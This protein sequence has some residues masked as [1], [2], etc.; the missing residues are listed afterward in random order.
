MH[1]NIQSVPLVLAMGLGF[2]GCGDS[3][4]VNPV[5]ELASLTVTPGTLQPAFSGGI[6]QYKV[7]LSNNI[8]S[9]TMTAQPA[10]AGDTVTINGQATTSRVIT[11]DA[12]GTTTPVNIVVSESGTNSRTYTVLLT[13]AGLTGNN[14][15]RSLSISP[16]PLDPRFN[17]NTLSYEVSVGSGVDSIR[18]TPAL[19][20]PAATLTVNGQAALSGQAQTI[21]LRDPGLST[22]LTIMVTA[23]NGTPK[24][25]TVVVSRAA[26]SDDNNLEALSVTA[27]TLDPGFSAETEQYEVD[28]AHTVT[29]ITV[30]AAKSDPNAVISGD[31]P[32]Q[33]SAN[34]QL[35][36][37]GTSTTV[38]I[39]V[40][41][42]SGRQK[43]YRL[44]VNRLVPSSDNNLSSLTVAPGSL[45][46]GFSPNNP[47]L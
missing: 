4:T 6:T 26:L 46:P 10:V 20:D 13:K 5:V 19:E 34:I 14:S 17:A 1:Y 37:P 15:L 47:D 35:G 28:V 2:S 8:T 33:G 43:T 36:G 32:N 11:L 42:P 3:A 12:A 38:S 31:L 16:G 22:I 24:S 30:T 23:Q 45:S 7:D 18:V 39:V 27:G 25:Y 41:A 29:S 40:T 21:P 9:V 44:T